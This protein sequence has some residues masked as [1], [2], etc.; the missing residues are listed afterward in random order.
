MVGSK[1]KSM[2]PSVPEILSIRVYVE[3]AKYY[4]IF[5]GD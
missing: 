4:R 3:I 5:I 2:S 1:G